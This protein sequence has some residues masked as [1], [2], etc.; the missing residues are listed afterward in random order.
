[1]YIC[2]HLYFSIDMIAKG[3]DI[4]FNGYINDDINGDLTVFETFQVHSCILYGNDK[5][6]C[7]VHTSI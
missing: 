1:M 2:A 7:N 5:Y 4:L 6:I 3:V